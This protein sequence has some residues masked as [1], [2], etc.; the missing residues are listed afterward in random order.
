ML[1]R[2]VW[3]RG[4]LAS[5]PSF[6]ALRHTAGVVA[7]C[8]LG[9]SCREREAQAVD[10]QTADA[11][12]AQELKVGDPAPDFALTGSDGKVYELQAFRGRQVVVIAWFAKAFTG[13]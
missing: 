12:V 2:G 9:A 13:A 6:A 7:L 5:M 4:I 11:G 3:E 10:P 1:C 8:L